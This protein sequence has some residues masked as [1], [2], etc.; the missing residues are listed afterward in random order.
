[1]IT[2]VVFDES[3]QSALPEDMSGWFSK[4]YALKQIDN[5]DYLNTSE[6]RGMT[7]TF[8][9]CISLTSLDLS[10]FDVEKVEYFNRMFYDCTALTELNLRE[11]NLNPYAETT[12][13]MFA[14]CAELTTIY[15]N[16]TWEA[17]WNG[18][19]TDNMFSG[20]VKL[21]GGNNTAYDAN[22][23]KLHYARPGKDGQPGYFTEIHDETGLESIQNSDIRSQKILRDGQLLIEKNGKTYTVTGAEVK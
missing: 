9:N 17:K 2:N 20:C 3:V 18:M 21:V 4:F 23:V 16:H 19:T 7:E 15:C 10:S 14:G 12:V 13:G 8:M 1:M 11:W 22:Y 6:V 5:L